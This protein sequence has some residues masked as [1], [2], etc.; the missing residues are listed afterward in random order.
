[1][2]SIC[3]FGDSKNTV[4]VPLFSEGHGSDGS[5]ECVPIPDFFF[6]LAHTPRLRY[7]KLL[8][9][10]MQ[11]NIGP[12][13]PH[14]LD[15]L[16]DL[17]LPIEALHLDDGVR[18]HSTFVYE[19]VG[20][21][22]T[23]KA[24]RVVASH[25]NE[26]PPERPNISLRELRLSITPLDKLIEV[27][28]WLLPPPP[29]NEQSNLRFLEPNKFP[30]EALP[31][32][33]VHGPSVSTLMLRRQPAFE[34]ANLFTKLDGLVNT[35]LLW[36]SPLPAFPRTLKHIMLHGNSSMSI[37]VLAAIAQAVPMLPHLR[38][39]SIKKALTTQTHYA[40]L[41]EACKTHRVE[42]LVYSVYSSGR[43]VVST[44]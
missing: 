21:W 11:K 36:S 1:M 25:T 44:H 23:I 14:I 31:V 19:L 28:E 38:I 6:L 35:G 3:V 26:V 7:L 40:D 17:V 29:P 39:L 24:L 33:S 30:K 12:L 8:L 15:W 4:T 10:F 18:L 42:I 27:I 20:T 32:L 9:L 37:S 43:T 41:Q 22:P 34:I 5:Q 16:S 13:V 2:L